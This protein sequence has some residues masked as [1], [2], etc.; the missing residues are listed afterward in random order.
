M[1][2]NVPVVYEMMAVPRGK[3]RAKRFRVR[4]YV[5]IDVPVVDPQEAPIALEWE[6]EVHPSIKHKGVPL[7]DLL[8]PWPQDGKMHTRLIGEDQFQLLVD[9]HYGASGR[10]ASADTLADI[11]QHW[12]SSPPENGNSVSV[13]LHSEP[14]T[15]L[16]DRISSSGRESAVAELRYNT[17]WLRLVNGLLY[18]GTPEPQVMVVKCTFDP[19][20]DGS[21]H[22]CMLA[23]VK[24]QASDGF[25]SAT[26][27]FPV[28]SWRQAVAKANKDNADRPELETAIREM[29]ARLRPKVN[30]SIL[31]DYA[32]NHAI[33]SAMAKF[34]D[35]IA[36]E[37]LGDLSRSGALLACQLMDAYDKMMEPGGLDSL[38]ALGSAFIANAN[39]Q[40]VAAER[41]AAKEIASVISSLSD[42]EITLPEV[43]LAA[44]TR[45]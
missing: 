1:L 20:G 25:N 7:R 26:A 45:F 24:T 13:T 43:A 40:G 28:G 10:P 17:E 22:P 34:Y 41:K 44:P 6:G 29:H 4:E 33:Y 39:K 42:R 15:D 3:A 8:P 38:E 31:G 23:L 14:G 32:E 11:T 36:C 19:D 37:R 5:E 12:V 30:R 2:F 9:G 27:V 21:D 18:V 16:F 35:I